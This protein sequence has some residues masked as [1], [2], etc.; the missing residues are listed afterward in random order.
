MRLYNPSQIKSFTQLRQLLNQNQL[1]V[2][3]INTHPTLEYTLTEIVW[4]ELEPQSSGLLVSFFLGE[5]R[6]KYTHVES[7]RKKGLT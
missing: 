2:F 6:S 3:T 7:T 1:F 5:G 4:E